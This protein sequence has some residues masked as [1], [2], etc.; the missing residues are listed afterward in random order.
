MASSIPFEAMRCGTF[1]RVSIDVRR[2]LVVDLF[3][4]AGGCHSV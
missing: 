1:K 3:A 4:G 2:P